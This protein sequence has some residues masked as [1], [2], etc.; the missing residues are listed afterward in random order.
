MGSYL[1]PQASATGSAQDALSREARPTRGLCEHGTRT[2]RGQTRGTHTKCGLKTAA[3]DA[4]GTLLNCLS[5]GVRV[6]SFSTVS[7]L[8]MP[9]LFQH[10]YSDAHNS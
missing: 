2:R 8:N 10:S 3:G 4:R 7:S 5:Y 1:S 9:S 6:G